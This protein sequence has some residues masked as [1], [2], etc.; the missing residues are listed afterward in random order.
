[1]SMH[2]QY[3][4]KQDAD[5]IMLFPASFLWISI[6]FELTQLCTSGPFNTLTPL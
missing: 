3:Q 5:Q 2:Y 4:Q 1:M 6:S